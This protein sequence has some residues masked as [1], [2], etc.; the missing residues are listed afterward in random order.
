MTEEIKETLNCIK[1]SETIFGG[2]YYIVHSDFIIALEEELKKINV[3][4][5]VE[6]KELDGKKIINEI[7]RNQ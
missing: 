2:E 6:I 3:N 4:I 1:D 5:T 7:R